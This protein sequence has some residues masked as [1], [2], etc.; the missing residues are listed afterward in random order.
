M[1]SNAL[2]ELLEQKK[3]EEKVNIS[4]VIEV[5]RERKIFFSHYEK[6]INKEKEK[7][8]NKNKIIKKKIEEKVETEKEKEKEDLN[9]LNSKRRSNRIH[10]EP[11]QEAKQ[12][13]K[14]EEP[15]LKYPEPR[16]TLVKEKKEEV[17]SISNSKIFVNNKTKAINSNEEKKDSESPEKS[18]N[19]KKEIKMSKI[20]RNVRIFILSRHEKN[21]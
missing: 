7:D 14:K 8:K 2:K 5:K 13:I 12:E 11:K 20:P 6:S 3:E 21:F 17:S 4:E 10:K 15:K 1:E 18:E 16:K 19:K 9:R